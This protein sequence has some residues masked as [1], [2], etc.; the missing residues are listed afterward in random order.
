MSR[1]IFSDNPT[2]ELSSI[3]DSLN[4]D[5]VMI[6]TDRNVAAAARS[7]A[8]GL[9]ENPNLKLIEIPAG[10]DNKSMLSLTKIWSELA[11]GG[12]SRDSLLVCLGG[13][14]VTDIGGFAAGTF[15]RGIR[16]LN[17]PTTLLGAVDAAIGGK[18]AI[19]FDG[20]K[21]EIGM[22]HSPEAVIISPSPFTTL[23]SRQLANGYAEMIKTALIADDN[24]YHKIKDYHALAADAV[25]MAKGAKSVAEIKM[26]V[27]SA[28]PL[29]KGLR[30][31][32]NFGH[33]FGHALE[34][35][36]LKKEWPLLHGEAVAHGILVAL[37]LS[38]TIL[39]LP[40]GIIYSFT[41]E[42]LREL[43]PMVR[44]SCDDYP[45]LIKLMHRDKKNRAGENTRFV[46]IPRIGE[47]RHDIPVSDN[48]IA[49][50]LDIYRDLLSF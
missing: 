35:F 50:A 38:H 12:C 4:P 15:K 23:P 43:Y 39:N 49:T 2:I 48:D 25:E 41:S 7:F 46:L 18:T 26:R 31:I 37:I 47:A 14:M 9:I 16:H 11:S 40:S 20:I 29:D 27:V 34:S 45:E 6:L 36:S 30:K 10:E 22:F 5:R 28:D 21:N 13:G 17:I 24:L 3:I 33:T 19:D 32:L 42:I 8:P 1:L 44:F